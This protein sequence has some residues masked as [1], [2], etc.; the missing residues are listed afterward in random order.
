MRR[1]AHE[2]NAAAASF[3]LSM[4]GSTR[5]RYKSTV[6]ALCMVNG[7]KV[8]SIDPIEDVTSPVERQRWCEGTR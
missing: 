1:G 2:D 8:P 6:R 7:V 3:R 5:V 4:L